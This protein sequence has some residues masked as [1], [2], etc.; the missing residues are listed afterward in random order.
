MSDLLPWVVIVAMPLI[1]ICI[2]L[3]VA[4][5]QKAID[6]YRDIIAIQDDQI[7]LLLEILDDNGIRLTTSRGEK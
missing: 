5:Y 1:G 3:M 4:N 7:D 2:V 6:A